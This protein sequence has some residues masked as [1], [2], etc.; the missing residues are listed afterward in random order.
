MKTLWENHGTKVLGSLGITIG[1]LAAMDPTMITALL[2]AVLGAR[3]PGIATTILGI[4]TFWRGF[5][6]TKKTL[7]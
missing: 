5:Q 2:S 3:G 4:L 1:T 6:N 7:P